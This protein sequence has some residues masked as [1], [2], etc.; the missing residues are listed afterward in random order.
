MFDILHVTPAQNAQVMLQAVCFCGFMHM[1]NLNLQLKSQRLAIHM[2]LDAHF[3]YLD[4]EVWC[5]SES[6][7][8]CVSHLMDE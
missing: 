8:H 2:H 7:S 1:R 4:T 3:V 5:D 6:L